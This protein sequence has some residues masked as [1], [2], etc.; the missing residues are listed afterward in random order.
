MARACLNN[1]QYVIIQT[2]AQHSH[3]FIFVLLNHPPSSRIRG[4]GALR[5]GFNFAAACLFS[6]INYIIYLFIAPVV[7]CYGYGVKIN[8]EEL[9]K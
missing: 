1:P 5:I 8:H 2:I 3:P 9:Y 4:G 7:F 6:A